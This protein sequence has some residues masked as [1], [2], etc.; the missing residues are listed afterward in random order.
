M[1]KLLTTIL[2]AAPV[3]FCAGACTDFLYEGEIDLTPVETEETD[4]FVYPEAYEFQHPGAL[5]TKSDLDRVRAKVQ[6]YTDNPAGAETD[7]VWQCW[8]QLCQSPYAQTTFK[9]NPVETLV[10]GDPTNTGTTQNYMNA[11]RA[12]AAAFQLGLR[13]QISGD[14]QYADKAVSILNEWADV[15]KRITSNDADFNLLAGFQGYQFANAAELLRDYQGWQVADQEDFKKWLEDVWYRINRE[16]IET[17]GGS[18]VCDLHYWSNWEL[19][20]LASILAI[21]IYTENSE[22]VRFVYENF[23]EGDGSGALHNMIPGYKTLDTYNG[24]GKKIEDTPGHFI[25]QCMESG[26]DQGHATLVSS[27]CAELCQMAGNVRVAGT[28]EYLDF[29]GMDDNLV[30]AMF[31]YTAMYNSMPYATTM[32]F[33]EYEYCQEGCGCSGGHSQHHLAV[34][35]DGQGTLRPCWDLIYNHYKGLVPETQLTYSKRFAEQLRTSGGILTGDCGAGDNR[36]NN[37]KGD[38]TSAT[39]DQLGWGTL[40]FYRNGQ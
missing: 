20:N 38:E 29:F 22:M 28:D 8:K 27:V 34:S 13:Y 4:D 19:G 24:E 35:S 9:N 17:H 37:D 30:L 11:C 39:F 18:N 26:R 23:R 2:V 32:P 10:R 12:A 14:A 6:Q 7:P 15:C 36:Y 31:E 21:G 33:E 16:F 5:V 1:K 25:A 40:L 3:L